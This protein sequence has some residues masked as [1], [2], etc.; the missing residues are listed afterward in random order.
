MMPQRFPLLPD[1]S[2]ARRGDLANPPAR[3]CPRTTSPSRSTWPAPPT[4]GTR[5]GPSASSSRVAN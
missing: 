5:A 1:S 4:P 3:I 2:P